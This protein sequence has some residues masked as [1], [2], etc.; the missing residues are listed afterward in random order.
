MCSCRKA[1]PSRNW[2]IAQC[3]MLKW[4]QNGSYPVLWN[5]TGSG[6]QILYSFSGTRMNELNEWKQ[7]QSQEINV[8][9]TKSL[10]SGWPQLKSRLCHL[11]ASFVIFGPVT[12]CF[13]TCFLI[14][15]MGITETPL[16]RFVWGFSEVIAKHK[17]GI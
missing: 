16:G 8:E 9:R 4:F 13:P 3:S 6:D 7:K 12:L 5:C 10:R 15:G 1:M 14:C 11:L 2:R 17:T